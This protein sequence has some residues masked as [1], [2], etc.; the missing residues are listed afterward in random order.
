MKTGDEV[1]ELT[2][3]NGQVAKAVELDFEIKASPWTVIE[4]S[5]GAEIKFWPHIRQIFRLLDN[6]TNTGEPAY[7]IQTGDNDARSRSPK[8]L[9]K[10]LKAPDNREVA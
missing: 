2:L 1:I 8:E 10:K 7:L 5:E 6:Y 4:T 3:P 9:K